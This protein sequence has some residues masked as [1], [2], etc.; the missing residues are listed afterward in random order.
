MTKVR[1]YELAKELNM[2]SK[3]LMEKIEGLELKINSH[4]S[5]IEDEEAQLIKELLTEDKTEGKAVIED[6]LEIFDEDEKPK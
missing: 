3:A 6:E 2:S 4:M 1:I 5:S